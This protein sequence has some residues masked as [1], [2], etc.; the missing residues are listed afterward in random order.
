[1]NRSGSVSVGAL[2]SLDNEEED[3]VQQVAQNVHVDRDGVV[4]VSPSIPMNQHRELKMRVR[5][6]EQELSLNRAKVDELQ[7]QR[8]SVDSMCDELRSK[9][10]QKTGEVEKLR[11]RLTSQDIENSAVL[12]DNAAARR[13]KESLLRRA[14]AISR[15]LDTALEERDSAF[16]AR[17]VAQ[18]KCAEITEKINLIQRELFQK[19]AIIGEAKHLSDKLSQRIEE[20]E[21]HCQNIDEER[22]KAFS[23]RDAMEKDLSL[24]RQER[25]DAMEGRKTAEYRLQEVITK[26]RGLQGQFFSLEGELEDSKRACEEL[27]NEAR[28]RNIEVS[29]L[30][31]EK[32]DAMKARRNAIDAAKDAAQGRKNAEMRAR[33]A[34]DLLGEATRSLEMVRRERDSLRDQIRNTLRERDHFEAKSKELLN[35][36]ELNEEQAAEL[37]A[38]RAQIEVYREEVNA[39][40]KLSH[41]R[42]SEL[43]QSRMKVKILEQAAEA[44]KESSNV[45]EESQKEELTKLQTQNKT[46]IESIHELHDTKSN[47]LFESQK[48][49]QLLR[50]ALENGKV[51]KQSCVDGQMKFQELYGHYLRLV[52]LVKEKVAKYDGSSFISKSKHQQEVQGLTLR[53]DELQK[54]K[55]DLKGRIRSLEDELRDIRADALR[56]EASYDQQKSNLESAH[57]KQISRIKELEVHLQELQ[58]KI[59][60]LMSENNDVK[61][62]LSASLNDVRVLEDKNAHLDSQLADKNTERELER[63]KI[64]HDS[65]MKRMEGQ[66]AML[67]DELAHKRNE[68][69]AE[70]KRLRDNHSKE[71]EAVNEAART[72][73]ALQSSHEANTISELQ[74]ALEEERKL[75]SSLKLELQKVNDRL[76]A[77]EASVSDSRTQLLRS[78]EKRRIAEQKL[79]DS[80]RK[81]ARTREAL[82]AQQKRRDNEMRVHQSKEV[83]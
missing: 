61:E 45:F 71:M 55:R 35:Q 47:I 14:Q 38:L 56:K 30:L 51:L 70:M 15:E 29:R 3:S 13:E 25:D 41:E 23:S 19:D 78:A 20:L 62:K 6:L 75:V 1:M 37:P 66:C 27:E 10:R 17:Q 60:S 83:R 76:I 9:V 63:L 64:M 73:R 32:E 26:L 21:E 67:R 31:Q 34:Q 50:A 80:E 81:L 40:Q 54:D 68:F 58:K 69:N 82:D 28:I 57:A 36:A 8:A 48:Q 22:Q 79:L 2:R 24:V 74:H 43:Q 59:Q 46:L 42:L 65:E 4:T 5:E 11:E 16:A 39:T 18:S 33:D 52:G 53:I 7:R 72:A 49:A 77:E 44:R 12:S